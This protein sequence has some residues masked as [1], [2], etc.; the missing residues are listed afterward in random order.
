MRFRSAAAV[1]ALFALVPT[2]PGAALSPHA[3]GDADAWD[4]HP[5]R[6]LDPVYDTAFPG[7]AGDLMS[8]RFVRVGNQLIFRAGVMNLLHEPSADVVFL[9]DCRAGGSHEL[10]GTDDAR[11]PF[12][13]DFALRVSGG[14]GDARVRSSVAGELRASS[15]PALAAITPDADMVEASVAAPSFLPAADSF[16]I[17][18]VTLSDGRL[19][20]TIVT[21]ANSRVGAKNVSFVQHGNQGLTWSSVFL[22]E[23][24]EASTSPG[25][26]NNPDDGFDEVLEAHSFYSIPGCFHLASTL[27]ASAEWHNPA[28]NDSLV[29]GVAAGWADM[30][31]SAYAQHMMPFVR[32]EMNDWSVHVEKNM[33]D[34]RYGTNSTVAWVPERVWV[35]SPDTDGN[36]TDASCGVVDAT[37]SDNWLPHGVEAVILDDYIHGAY[38]DDALNDRHILV[39]PNGLKVIPIDNTFV[40]DL[41]WD[42]GTAWNTI[43]TLSS[44]E[45][46]VYGNDWEMVAEVSQGASNMDALNNYIQVL[47]QCSLNSGT[48]SAWKISDAIHE[49]AF[50]SGVSGPIIQNG[51]YGLLGGFGGY[52]GACN[53][54]YT[55]WAAYADPQHQWDQHSPVWDYGT[56]WNN[57]YTKIMGVPQNSLSESAWYVMM[58]NLHETGWHDD[59]QISGWIYRYSNHIHNAN[60]YAEAA[61]WADGL[62]ATTTGAYLEDIDMDGQTEAVI[63]NDRV[64]AVFE[65][66][67]GRAAWIFAKG[68]T[69]ADYEYSVAGNCNVY[70]SSTEG[71][72]NEGNHIACLSDVSVSGVDREHEPYAF[73]IVQGAGSTVSLE[74]AHPSVTKTVSLTLGDKYLD[75]AYLAASDNVY[76]KNA[77]SPDL[78]D[79]AWNARTER[80]WSPAPSGSWFGHRNPNTGATGA[81]VVGSAGATHNFQ[82]SSTLLEGDELRGPRKFRIYLFAGETTTPDSSGALAELDALAA[83]L[84][85]T[86]PPAAISASYYP[87]PDKLTISFDET[88]AHATVSV[89]GFGIDADNDGVAEVALSP[90]C[91]VLNTADSDRIDITLDTTTAAALEA[92]GGSAELLMAA[93]TV[94]DGSGI[95]NDPLDHT[96]DV[97]VAIQP[98]TLITIDGEFDA[99]EWTPSTLVVDDFWDSGW[100]TPAPGDTN[101]INAL[102]VTWDSAFV[103]LGVLG[104]VSGNSWLLYLDADPGG[105]N[106]SA[107]LSAINTWERGTVFTGGFRADFQYGCYQ[108]QSAYDGDNFWR[109]DTDTTTTDLSSSVMTAFDSMHSHGDQGGS[110]LAIPWDVLYGMGVG[111]VPP[112]AGLAMVASICWDPDPSGELGGDSAP[113]N[114]TATLPTIDRWISFTV[115]ADGDG[116]PDA[117]PPAVGVAAL[118]TAVT[119]PIISSVVPNP[120]SPTTRVTF[121]LPGDTRP[122]EVARLEVFDVGGR[123][124]RVLHNGPANAGAHTVVWDGTDASGSHLAA[125][126]FFAKLSA[127]GGHSTKK[128][129]LLR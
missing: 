47:R 23:R 9:V 80:I 51:T 26:V 82:F 12:A 65:P 88:V 44:D 21:A 91:V 48:V 7:S 71:D 73:Q 19:Q 57:T 1:L 4:S 79:L 124:V 83:G 40:G 127:P 121:A 72:Y 64:M 78:V 93:A 81:V 75:I 2:A 24:G 13:W 105:P 16:R 119:Q 92:L 59:G 33:T 10:P 50:I 32:D 84:T 35:E 54:W 87:N 111:A 103:Y 27:Q 22:G 110:E 100:T 30:V 107:D 76:V 109:I 14:P 25:D 66:A 8:L 125:G 49:P 31:T 61:R 11:A 95:G 101:D 74:L 86:F 90:G 68:P 77:F 28:F 129:V 55:D 45:L 115:D 43:I 34:W 114:A 58:T 39:L 42:W 102:H 53:S 67:G 117:T 104:K 89:T 41:N 106:G 128:L 62:Y 20:D 108:H 118:P 38:Y 98:P 126:V 6:A 36:G 113:D 120:F 3:L 29:A 99:A 123:S 56:I 70:W 97:P 112:G 15:L 96:G 18:A 52:G 60:A 37:I 122:G 46:L 94:F 116:V 69:L 85:D 5:I 63:Y 17:A